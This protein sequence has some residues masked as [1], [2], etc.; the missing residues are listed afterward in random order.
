MQLQN[1]IEL[2]RRG[3][4]VLIVDREGHGNYENTGDTGAM[5][6]TSGLYDSAKYL[7]N[8]DY[9]DKDRIGISGHSMGGYTTAMVLMQDNAEN[10]GLGIV[11][12]GL[13]QSWS[14]FLAR[15]ATFRSVSSN[16]KTTNSFIRPTKT[17]A[18]FPVS[19]C[20]PKPQKD[21][22]A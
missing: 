4:V 19:G 10:G 13:I 21:M 6:A 22:S 12:A 18:R 11:S 20:P 17:A 16:P 15:A 5:M 8:L 14:T 7:Y 9:V 1:A 3:F 2:A